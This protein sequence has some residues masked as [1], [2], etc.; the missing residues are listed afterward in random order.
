MSH[1]CAAANAAEDG[2]VNNIHALNIG[3]LRDSDHEKVNEKAC[4]AMVD[5]ALQNSAMQCAQRHQRL[6]AGAVVDFGIMTIRLQVLKAKCVKSE[7]RTN[8][9]SARVTRLRTKRHIIVVEKAVS[10]KSNIVD[11]DIQAVNPMSDDDF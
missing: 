11:E 2:C 1:R 9:R 5:A 10:C 6:K 3:K 4:A 8:A 7:Q